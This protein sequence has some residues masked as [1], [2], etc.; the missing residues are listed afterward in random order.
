MYVFL[1]LVLLIITKII[2]IITASMKRRAAGMQARIF[3]ASLERR[4]KKL[5]VVVVV[6]V[7]IDQKRK[8]W[9]KGV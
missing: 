9:Q 2:R 6:V 4:K 5:V 1:F 8:G 3:D 7:V